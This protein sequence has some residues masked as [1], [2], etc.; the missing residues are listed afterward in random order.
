[1]YTTSTENIAREGENFFFLENI[2]RILAFYQ[3]KKYVY[4]TF[5]RN[6]IK[7]EKNIHLHSFYFKQ[8]K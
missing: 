5:Q 6:N 7:R 8:N 2:T 3:P 4:F 1:M